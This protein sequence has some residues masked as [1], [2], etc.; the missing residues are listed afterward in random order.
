MGGVVEWIAVPETARQWQ[1]EVPLLRLHR[2]SHE[3]CQAKYSVG[4]DT[5]HHG[6]FKFT[7]GVSL[8]GEATIAARA[9]ETYTA[10]ENCIEVVIKATL[11]MALFSVRVNGEEHQRRWDASVTAVEDNVK[12]PQALASEADGCSLVYEQAM[13]LPA[14]ES[15][16]LGQ[17]GDPASVETEVTFE[18]T[19]K[20]TLGLKLEKG[21][22]GLELGLERETTDTTTV[23]T[24]LVRGC[25]YAVYVPASGSTLERCWTVD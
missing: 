9:T 17:A 21:P 16:D 6:S 15:W 7:V 14:F 25:R 13:Q 8:G 19:T 4:R 24:T 22:V 2:P 3:G 18:S 10:N 23:A 20:G 5:S 1:I 11:A 12:D